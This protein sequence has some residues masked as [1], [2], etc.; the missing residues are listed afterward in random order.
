MPSSANGSS[1]R[2]CL[3]AAGWPEHIKLA[4]NLSPAQFRKRDLVD[5]V[6]EALETSGLW[7][8]RLELEITETV[9]LQDDEENLAMLHQLRTFGI[10]IV[11]DDF[12]TGYSSLS[13]LQRLPVRQDQDRPVVRR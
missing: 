10:S 1:G 13:Y 8:G 7:P 5:T 3:D 2:A 4:V 9:L 11:L 12:G 6:T